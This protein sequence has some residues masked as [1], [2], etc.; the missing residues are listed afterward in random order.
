MPK[1]KNNTAPEKTPDPLSQPWITFKSGLI[2]VG[3]VS[4]I[5][6]IWVTI[7]S[8]PAIPFF[9]RLGWGLVF[10]G[11]VWVVFL[12]FLLINRLFRRRR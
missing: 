11:S 2:T 8:N 4:I 5:L 3:V 7:T 9:E 10:G 6:M 12:F 1:N